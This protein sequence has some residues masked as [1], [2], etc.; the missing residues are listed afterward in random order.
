V[1]GRIS[2]HDLEFADLTAGKVFGP[3]DCPSSDAVREA[4]LRVAHRYP[5]NRLFATVERTRFG[6]ARW[7]RRTPAEL[8]RYCVEMV[9]D[10]DGDGDVDTDALLNLVSAPAHADKLAHYWVGNGY[11]ASNRSHLLGD[12]AFTY[13]TPAVLRIALGEPVPDLPDAASARLPLTRAVVSSFGRR[14]GRIID[15][16]RVPRPEVAPSGDSITIPRSWRFTAVGRAAGADTVAALRAWRDAMR[17]SASVANTWSAAIRS[18]FEA[19]GVQ[20]ASPGFHVLVN[21]RR[22]LPADTTV[23]GNFATALYVEPSDPRDP[24]AVD[25]IV[26][27]NL[28]SGRPL[29]SMAASAFKQALPKRKADEPAELTVDRLPTLTVSYVGLR[30]AYEPLPADRAH[31]GHYSAVRPDG[32][33]GIT[34]ICSLTHG[35]MS[36]SAS[37]CR[38]VVE[39]APVIDALERLAKD[40]VGLLSASLAERSGSGGL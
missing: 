22:Y 16:L 31:I 5:D 30:T 15:A 20:F 36:L 11:V 38:D 6:G 21:A 23:N 39:P 27:R 2:V 34:V 10:I 18:A 19:A 35:R 25:A 32:P 7:G 8:E 26:R 29:L 1:G 13:L 37:F 9:S 12:T 28:E 4:L 17:P 40:P 33:S 3:F 14:P 24:A